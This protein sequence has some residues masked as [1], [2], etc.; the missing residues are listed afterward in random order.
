M[1][2]EVMVVLRFYFLFF[3]RQVLGMSIIKNN[4]VKIYLAIMGVVLYC[5]IFIAFYMFISADQIKFEHVEFILNAYTINIALITY[6][7]FIIIKFFFISNT[8]VEEK[9]KIFPISNRMIRLSSLL[10]ECIIYI[11]VSASITTIIIVPMVLLYKTAILPTILNNVVFTSIS[12]YISLHLMY[13]LLL[14]MFNTEKRRRIFPL[15]FVLFSVMLMIVM[16]EYSNDMVMKLSVDFLKDGDKSF[17]FLFWQ[18]ITTKTSFLFSLLAFILYSTISIYLIIT[19]T[20]N[21]SLGNYKYLNIK[22]TKHGYIAC[23]VKSNV[24]K[25][26]NN[27]NIIIYYLLFITFS[28][29]GYSTVVLSPLISIATLYAFSNTYVIRKYYYSMN[30]SNVKEYFNL[31]FSQAIYGMIVLTPT[32]I[33]AQDIVVIFQLILCYM[34]SMMIMLLLGILFPSKEENPLTPLLSFAV[35][36]IIIMFTILFISILQLSRI[37]IYVIVVL[38]VFFVIMLSCYGISKIMEGE[39]K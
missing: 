30:S 33:L 7:L 13:N 23:L 25:L 15:F 32:L 19:T 18:N 22:I 34:V 6:L 27:V 20:S 9:L 4:F 24:R 5:T 36:F 8:D 28:I 31:L 12:I 21:D 35:F 14:K 16:V 39:R 38:T 26:S 2:S 11:V 3:V 17:I 1:I 10:L 37:Q 29:I